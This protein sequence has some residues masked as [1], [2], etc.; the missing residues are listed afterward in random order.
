MKAS[1]YL[2]IGGK[3]DGNGKKVSIYDEDRYYDQYPDLPSGRFGHACA[4]FING[5]GETVG[6]FNCIKSNRKVKKLFFGTV[7][8]FQTESFP[9]RLKHSD[10]SRL[11]RYCAL[12]GGTMT[13]Q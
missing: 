9:L 3:G 2:V 6:I 12:I 1:I 4:K 8:H 13:T 10:S 11:S 7:S 5:N